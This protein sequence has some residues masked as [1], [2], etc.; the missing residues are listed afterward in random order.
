M[1]HNKLF[2]KVIKTITK[3]WGWEKRFFLGERKINFSSSHTLEKLINLIEDSKSYRKP[4]SILGK[5]FKRSF[6]VKITKENSICIKQKG[7]WSFWPPIYYYKGIVTE[8]DGKSYINGEYKMSMPLKV[9]IV[10]WGNIHL[11]FIIVILAFC[12]I[13]LFK[14]LVNIVNIIVVE[15][16]MFDFGFA[17]ITFVVVFLIFKIMQLNQGPRGFISFLA[18]YNV[19]TEI[20]TENSQV[21]T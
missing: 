9:V 12:L 5:L 18:G 14:Y 16:L 21:Q 19:R 6:E 4:P 3:F 7:N 15:K 10:L 11:L 2:N 1:L 20:G 8:R 13:T 17:V